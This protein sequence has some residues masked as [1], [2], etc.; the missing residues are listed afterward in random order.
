MSPSLRLT[1]DH[2]ARVHRAVE[3]PGPVPGVVQQTDAD[4]AEWVGH[5]LSA[6][7]APMTNSAATPTRPKKAKS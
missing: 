4:Y 7:P 2:I 1:P 6:N 5:I 3:D